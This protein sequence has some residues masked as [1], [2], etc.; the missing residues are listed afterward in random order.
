M[1]CDPEVE[2]QWPNELLMHSYFVPEYIFYEMLHWC[3]I[4]NNTMTNV[5]HNVLHKCD[6]R[7]N[8]LFK[9]KNTKPYNQIIEIDPIIFFL[10]LS[11]HL[12][13]CL[14][15]NNLMR[16]VHKPDFELMTCFRSPL[17]KMTCY[18]CLG[19]QL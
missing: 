3:N 2:P 8:L 19:S 13:M 14:T 11:Y 18:F 1:T 10:I 5:T 7:C 16:I 17:H 12:D 9:K 4:R 15:V 6:G